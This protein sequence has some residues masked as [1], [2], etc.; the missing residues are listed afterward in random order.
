MEGVMKKVKKYMRDKPHIAVSVPTA[1][2][3]GSFLTEL[4][5][6]FRDCGVTLQNIKDILAS[7]NGFEAMLLLIIMLILRKKNK[8]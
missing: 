1:L 3:C 6:A 5:Q 4:I 8:H 2:C 7:I